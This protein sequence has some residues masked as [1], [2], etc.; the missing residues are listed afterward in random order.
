VDTHCS[1]VPD[2]NG[3]DAPVI[4]M[5]LNVTVTAGKADETRQI[6]S[7][8]INQVALNGVTQEQLDKVVK[9]LCK[10]NA[11]DQQDNTY[12]MSMM[13]YYDKFG[14]DFDTDYV[15]TLQGFTTEDIRHFVATYIAPAKVLNLTMTPE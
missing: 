5:P 10:V 6:I 9:Y 8:D 2:Q 13:K 3:N 4:F 7:E 14:I 1:V 12:W 15:K 11:E